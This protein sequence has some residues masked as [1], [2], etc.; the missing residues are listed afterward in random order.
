MKQ[1]KIHYAWIILISCCIVNVIA[2]GMILGTVGVYMTPIAESLNVGQTK[3]SMIMTVEMLGMAI[4]MPI[5][6]GMMKKK[7]L[8]VLVT[9]SVLINAA[10]LMMVSFAQSVSIM[11][12]VWFV[13][14]AGVSV[15]L[16]LS[17][18]I[19]NWF[20]DKLGLATGISVAVSS[21]GTAIFNPVISMVVST[22]GWRVSY[23]ISAVVLVVILIP[24]AL[25][26][27]RYA[28]GEGES[29]YGADR[30][31][32][33]DENVMPASGVEDGLTLKEASKTGFFYVILISIAFFGATATF[34]QQVVPHLT[35][36]GFQP[37]VAALVLS[38]AC[39]S[40]AAGK[41]VLGP[42]LDGKHRNLFVCLFGILAAA[43]WMIIAQAPG[44]GI[45]MA[46][47][48]MAGLGQSVGMVAAPY[49]SRRAF[50]GKDIGKISG[51]IGVMSTI[52]PAVGIVISAMVFDRTGSFVSVFSFVAAE[53][54]VLTVLLAFGFDRFIRCRMTAESEA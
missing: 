1:R 14:G 46:G 11:Y 22:F 3:V 6:G 28:P 43:G 20:V 13:I 42:L 16:L 34:I 52:F 19:G 35:S 37:A 5:V 44:V 18:P 4:A 38:C 25:F 30:I 40:S 45:T 12:I 27:L 29:A 33:S 31:Q 10:G 47:G 23:R 9:V 21:V 24:V 7:P 17:V 41:L 2:Q 54:L 15:M 50:G 39:I 32:Q 36:K 51:I 49:M 53:I 26:T 8:K 48:L